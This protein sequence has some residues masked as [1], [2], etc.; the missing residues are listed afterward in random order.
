M[1]SITYNN[2]K[3]PGH[4]FL[5]SN[6]KSFGS[7]PTLLV[8]KRRIITN[9]KS[10]ATLSD[11]NQTSCDAVNGGYQPSLLQSR[12]NSVLSGNE[13]LSS[14]PSA[15]GSSRKS[16][17]GS[18]IPR[19]VTSNAANNSVFKNRST[20][21]SMDF[22]EGNRFYQNMTQTPGNTIVANHKRR[23]SEIKN[24][25]ASKLNFS[26]TRNRLSLS[27]FGD[28]EG[29]SGSRKS[30]ANANSQSS[31]PLKKPR[32]S[33]IGSESVGNNLSDAL[34]PRIKS[35]P[36]SNSESSKTDERNANVESASRRRVE[37][38]FLLSPSLDTSTDR[39]ISA[40]TTRSSKYFEIIALQLYF[41]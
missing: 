33:L 7:M 11:R 8:S 19:G 20:R 26:A 15:L 32:L 16:F 25:P 30:I 39:V 29:R 5:Q 2:L 31:I 38:T 23:I 1:P 22:G 37:M 3:V 10:S 18:A 28:H 27:L 9:G 35:L 40:K 12:S 21:K 13:P 14:L 24:T 41:I 36:T 17:T 34:T 4:T 6:R